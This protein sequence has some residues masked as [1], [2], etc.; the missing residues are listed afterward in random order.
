MRRRR[1]AARD[2]E[3]VLLWLLPVFA[4]FVEFGFAAG[5]WADEGADCL[6]PVALAGAFAELEEVESWA[7]AATG[8]NRVENAPA[9]ASA[10]TH[11]HLRPD[12]DTL[13]IF[14]RRSQ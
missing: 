1:A 2:R 3:A 7:E 4:D 8:K 6:V 10:A 13:S 11:H 12:R 14:A 9:H 5:L